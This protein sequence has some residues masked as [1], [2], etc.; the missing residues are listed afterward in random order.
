MGGRTVSGKRIRELRVEQ[1][2]NRKELARRSG[3]SYAYLKLIEAGACQPSDV[4]IHKIARGLNNVDIDDFTEP[5]AL[6]R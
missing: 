1:L 5:H 3:V 2:M 4:I 6:A